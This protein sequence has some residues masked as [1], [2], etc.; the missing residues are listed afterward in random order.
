[1]MQAA[2]LQPYLESGPP[3]EQPSV[4]AT[5]GVEEG[6]VDITSC[7]QVTSHSKISQTSG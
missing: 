7:I 2:H 6:D 1:M 3:Q 4:L 5:G